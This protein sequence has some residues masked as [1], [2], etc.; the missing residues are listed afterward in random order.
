MNGK[1]EIMKIVCKENLSL[2]RR[3]NIAPAQVERLTFASCSTRF[4]ELSNSQKRAEQLA[5]SR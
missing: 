4:R 1:A 2:L 3:T 5:E